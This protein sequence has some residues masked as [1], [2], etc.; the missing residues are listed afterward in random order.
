[1]ET[2]EGTPTGLR[3]WFGFYKDAVSAALDCGRTGEGTRQILD[4]LDFLSGIC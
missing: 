4:Q 2:G 1:V 3:I